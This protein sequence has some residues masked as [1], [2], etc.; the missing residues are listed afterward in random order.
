MPDTTVQAG[1]LDKIKQIIDSFGKAFESVCKNSG[2]DVSNGE[3]SAKGWKTYI[4]NRENGEGKFQMT[5]IPKDLDPEEFETSEDTEGSKGDETDEDKTEQKELEKK[6]NKQKFDL[7]FEILQ[8]QFPKDAV[9]QAAEDADV[10]LSDYI[11]ALEKA[12]KKKD[13]A[14]GNFEWNV[15]NVPFEKIGEA[16]AQAEEY[17]F[18]DVPP[19]FEDIYKYSKEG[20]REERQAAKQEKKE[21][22]TA[23][24]KV[25]LSKLTAAESTS[26]ELMSI[27]CDNP[28]GALGLVDLA[29]SD[30]EFIDSMPDGESEWE[31]NE[32]E[33]EIDIAELPTPIDGHEA[34]KE[35]YTQ[36]MA[37]VIHL[38]DE[39]Q[40]LNWNVCGE[41]YQQARCMLSDAIWGTTYI[42]DT[43]ADLLNEK[44]KYV[45][46]PCI[47]YPYECDADILPRPEAAI[48]AAKKA[49][50]NFVCV[51]ECYYCNIPHDVRPS[52]DNWIRDWSIRVNNLD[53]QL[54]DPIAVVAER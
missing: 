49:M 34:E 33:D 51:L 9:K 22:A 43:I 20:R 27:M 18:T 47:F 35:A 30:D 13:K 39:M 29:I 19:A 32:L 8:Y 38:R 26:V 53:R 42:L 12:W 14:C 50:R 5:T 41:D 3:E 4:I 40:F 21:E 46:H 23:S 52:V 36:M 37:A 2:Y 1:A 45:P 48:E 16:I 31:I 10:E 44:C 54:R 7:R 25:K 6:R 11:P 15:N 17:L 28:I 24:M